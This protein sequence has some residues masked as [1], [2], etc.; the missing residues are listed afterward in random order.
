MRLRDLLLEDIVGPDRMNPCYNKEPEAP[1]YVVNEEGSCVL[2]VSRPALV[3]VPM[4][5]GLDADSTTLALVKVAAEQ[6]STGI[7][8][9]GTFQPVQRHFNEQ[10]VPFHVVL[11][12]PDSPQLV[13]TPGVATL[14][15]TGV[16]PDRFYC[17]TTPENLGRRPTRPG[18]ALHGVKCPDTVGL[19]I[20]N[21]KGILTVFLEQGQRK[22]S[23]R[24]QA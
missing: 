13:P 9:D 1:A 20:F 23:I 11:R 17:L 7:E 12:H 10:R 5:E 6:G 4:V 8:W 24:P 22:Y 19:L 3:F 18:L 21:P 2:L 15:S 16:E 14:E